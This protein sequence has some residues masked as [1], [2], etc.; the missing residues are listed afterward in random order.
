M[1]TS[2]RLKL[3]LLSLFCL[4]ASLFAQSSEA[5][6]LDEARVETLI[7]SNNINVKGI[8]I[9]FDQAKRARDHMW[10]EFLPQIS[11]GVSSNRVYGYNQALLAHSNPTGGWVNQVTFGAQLNLTSWV[12]MGML[13]TQYEYEAGELSFEHAKQQIISSGLITFY[14]LLLSQ[15]RLNLLA[16]SVR[17][18]QE[19]YQQSSRLYNNGMVQQLDLLNAEVSY[20]NQLN[21][22]EQA[23][24]DYQEAELSFK[25]M[26]GIAFDQDVVLLGSVDLEPNKFDIDRTLAAFSGANLAI[27]QALKQQLANE[28]GL[29]YS[30]AAQTFTPFVRLDYAAQ[31]NTSPLSHAGLVSTSLMPR[32]SFSLTLG[33]SMNLDAMLPWSKTGQSLWKQRE[34]FYYQALKNDEDIITNEREIINQTQQINNIVERLLILQNAANVSERALEL[35][36]QGYNLG[37]RNQIELDQALIS[38]NQARLNLAVAKFDYFRALQELSVT[39]GQNPSTLMNFARGT[40][41]I[42]NTF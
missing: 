5:I 4:P 42:P 36:T 32:N 28:W 10:N 17:V 34:G 18:A 9:Q 11:A 24:I 30:H 7:I 38:R 39:T 22:Y 20:Q 25:Q 1:K 26:L 8:Q 12:W 41:N 21:Q 15:E 27:Q 29:W 33:F 3:G 23:L 14:S 6:F 16:D 13:K 31:Y 2:L 40:S 35:T 19:A 37:V